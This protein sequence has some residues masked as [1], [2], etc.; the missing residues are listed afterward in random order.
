ML[1]IGRVDYAEAIAPIQAIRRQVF[2][3]EQG[4][5]A[6]LEF[7]GED[8]TAIHFLAY[9]GDRAVGTTRIRYFP[10]TSVMIPDFVIAVIADNTTNTTNTCETV[11]KIE[12]VA[13]LAEC[14]GQK[15]GQQLM[16]EAIAY[17]N[18]QRITAIKLNAQLAV[19]AFYEQLGFHP[20]GAVFEEA[21]IPH[22]TMWY[23]PPSPPPLPDCDV[24][25]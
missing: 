23:I 9:Q 7:D 16:K 11:A 19:Q 17:L 14:R 21:G 20:Q 10:A 24:A 15:I 5:A 2:Q 13:V 3:E 18:Q 22:V 6:E 1:T 4:V 12:R 8:A 25:R